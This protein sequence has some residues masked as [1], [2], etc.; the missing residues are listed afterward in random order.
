ML[1][2][3]KLKEAVSTWIEK[4]GIPKTIVTCRCFHFPM[5]EL[6]HADPNPPNWIT[7]PDVVWPHGTVFLE[8]AMIYE[9]LDL[10]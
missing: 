6:F 8:H 9:R 7:L 10:N 3:H 4:H 1:L 2:E 5:K